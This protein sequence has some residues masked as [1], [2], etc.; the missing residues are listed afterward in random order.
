MARGFSGPQL[1]RRSCLSGKQCQ[2]GFSLH[3]A[4]QVCI[5]CN[6]FGGSSVETVLMKAAWAGYSPLLSHV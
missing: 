5:V 4:A 6:R 1:A 2:V 3:I